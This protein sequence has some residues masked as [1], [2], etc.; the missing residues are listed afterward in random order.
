MRPPAGIPSAWLRSLLPP[1]QH[2]VPLDIGARRDT[3][4]D[5]LHTHTKPLPDKEREGKRGKEKEK[6]KEKE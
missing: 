6:E 3:R 5:G 1:A 4:R 2:T